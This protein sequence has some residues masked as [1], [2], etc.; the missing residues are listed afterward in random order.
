VATQ[1]PDAKPYSFNKSIRFSSEFHTQKVQNNDNC[2]VVRGMQE[3]QEK[4]VS[5]CA[6]DC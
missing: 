4:S 5:V 6:N 3:L 1:P 2:D